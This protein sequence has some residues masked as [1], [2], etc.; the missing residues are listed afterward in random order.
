MTN[1]PLD[2]GWWLGPDGVSHPP[3]LDPESQPEP[4]VG[5]SPPP[6]FG[7]PDP[8]PLPSP[9]SSGDFPSREGLSGGRKPHRASKEALRDGVI[10]LARGADR[11]SAVVQHGVAAVRSALTDSGLAK[12]DKKTGEL[13]VK[14]LGLAKAALRP[15]KTLRKAVD[16]AALGDH[17]RALREHAASLPT[18]SEQSQDSQLGPNASERVRGT[19]TGGS[20]STAL[21]QGP[22]AGWNPDPEGMYEYRYWDGREWTDHVSSGGVVT[23][24]RM[25]SPAEPPAPN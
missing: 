5:A 11:P 20:A 3:G 25:F 18:S 24:H 17:V 9:P 1:R 13:H 23:S 2:P 21:P 22:I 12:E 7:Q 10:N 19:D 16:G 4:L 6:E 15:T 14:K 8:Q